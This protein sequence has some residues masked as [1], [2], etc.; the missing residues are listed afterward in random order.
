MEGP[1]TP[2]PYSEAPAYVPPL[3]LVWVGILPKMSP[4]T[5]QENTLLNLAPGSPVTRATRP[6]LGRGQRKS[7]RSS[8]SGSPISLGSP[9]V[10]LSLALAL[11]VHAHPPTPLVFGGGEEPSGDSDEEEEEM[12]ATEADAKQKED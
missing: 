2:P 7:E 1:K 11:K 10:T 8:C 5:D 4:V 3:D 12:D 6:G 9:A